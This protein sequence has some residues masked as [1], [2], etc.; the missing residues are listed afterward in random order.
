MNPLAK[1]R[2]LVFRSP[3]WRALRR[4][5]LTHYPTCAA[6]GG[7][8]KLEVHH[9][10]PVHVDRSLELR[11]DNLI[12]LCASGRRGLNCHLFVGHYGDFR[13]FNPTAPIDAEAIRWR[14]FERRG[15]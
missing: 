1:I 12:T 7:T 4:W 3:R 10:I 11:Q 15:Q 2:P 13:Q 9:I 6:C 5:H 8:S 14:F